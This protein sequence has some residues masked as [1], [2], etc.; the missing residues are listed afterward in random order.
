MNAIRRDLARPTVHA[1]NLW[2][3]S[4][5]MYDSWAIYEDG[6][7]T[8]LFGREFDNFS[9]PVPDIDIPQDEALKR[10]AQEETMSHAVFT[11]MRRRFINSPG[12]FDILTDMQDLM[13]RLGYDPT[14]LDSDYA[15][16]PTPAVLG[17][18]IGRCILDY[19]LVDGANEVQDYRNQFYQTV[20]PPLIVKFSGNDDLLNPNR[21]QQLTLDVFIDQAGNEIPFNT[22]EFL[23]P[24]WGAV[25]PFALTN[26]DLTIYQRDNFDYFVYHDPGPPP[27]LPDGDD[28]YFPEEYLWGFAMVVLWSSHLSPD[29]GVMIDISPASFGNSPE[30]PTEIEAYRDF[31]LEEGGDPGTGRDMNPHTGQPYE[32]QMVPRGDYTRVLA[33]FWA[34]GPDSETPPGHWFTILNEVMDD[35]DFN[36]TYKGEGDELDTLEYDVKAYFTLGGAMHDC[37]ISAWG[38]K[39]WYD[40]IRPI[41]AIRYI[42]S[43]GQSSDSNDISYHPNGI[44][45]FPGKIEIVRE[46]D[47][48]NDENNTNLGKIKIFAWRGPDFIFDPATDVAGVGWILAEDWWPYQRP[49]FVTPNF[50]GYVSGHSTYSRAAAEVLTFLTGDEYFPGGMG[51]FTIP[52]NE[53]LVFEDGPSVDMEL[54]WATYRDASDQTSLSRIW[55]GI[56]PPADDVPGRLIGIKIGTAAFEKAEKI[57]LG[58]TTPTTEVLHQTDRFNI[59][60]NPVS[61]T[62]QLHILKKD[63]Q[64]KISDIRIFDIQ[65]RLVA[66]IRDVQDRYDTGIQM[67]LNGLKAGYYTL[68][69]SHDNGLES[70]SLIVID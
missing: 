52:K 55:G 32:A 70:H 69:L 31:Y 43:L 37:A 66:G 45:L 59:F 1:R 68:L 9:C 51:T 8:F 19:G 49:S 46:D 41:S 2:H 65:G 16:N 14:N 47:E 48:L 35:V 7:N 13:E 34:D 3:S 28:G 17:N 54:Q 23:S 62:D 42:A 58:S 40:Y 50:A 64:T 56:H 6:P 57:F 18:Y 61:N 36:R 53:F 5:L 67:D 22:P 60:P 11:M 39:G 25:I 15:A 63:G 20:N 26:E 30:L 27:L 4:I 24:E 29:D 12:L 38:I 44:P 21:W 10:A 33:E